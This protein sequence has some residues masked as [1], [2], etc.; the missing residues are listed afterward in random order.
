MLQLEQSGA[1]SRDASPRPERHS[2]PFFGSRANLLAAALLRV[3][4]AEYTLRPSLRRRLRTAD[5][6]LNFSVGFC[7]EDGAVAQ[8]ISFR[9]GRVR[10]RSGVAADVD[11]TLTFQ[12][13]DA[14]LEMLRLPPNEALTLIMKN[15]VRVNGNMTWMSAFNHL[16]SLLTRRRTARALA[17]SRA[18]F[19]AEAESIAAG[20]EMRRPGDARGREERLAGD[21]SDAVRFLDDPYLGAYTLMDFPRLK[22]FLDIHFETRPEL[23]P[24]RPVILTEWFRE[25][26]FDTRADGTPWNPV[27]RQGEAF[28]HL[29]AARKPIVR[30]GDLLAGTTTGKEI[31]VVIYPDAHGTLIWGE[32]LTVGDRPINSYDVSP[33]D[34]AA[35]HD[36]YPFWT[37]RSFR[38]WVRDTY[39]EP[40]GQRID[41][42]LAV[43]FSVKTV[44]L[45]HT[46]PDFPRLLRKGARGMID[47]LDAELAGERHPDE[48][49][50]LRAMRLTLE[51][52]VAYGRNLAAECRRLAAAEQNPA[53]R[54]ELERMAAV[55]ERVP[56]HP[57]ETLDEAVQCVWTAWVGQHLENNNAGHS[58]G[59]L[60]QCLQPYFAADIA[61]LHGREDREAYVRHAIEL[62]GCLYMRCTDHL[63]LYPDL[64]NFLFGGASSD[65]AITLGGVTRDGESAVNDMTYVLLK[66]TELL[67]IRDPNVN[68]RY[69]LEE[70]SDA[71]LKRLCEVN[72]ITT[73][74]PSIHGDENVMRSIE[75][76]G[77]PLEDRRDWAPTGCVEPTIAGKHMGHTGCMMFSLVAALEM[78]LFDGRHP[79]MRW[80]LGPRTG[81]PAAAAHATFEDFFA[82]YA[83]QLAFLADQAT[84]YNHQL[85]EAHAVLRPTPFLSSMIEGTIESGRDVT[86]GGA[87]YNSSGVACIG[88]TDVVD[89]LLAVKHLVYDGTTSFAELIDALNADFA[90]YDELY[91]LTRGAAPKFGSG[92]REALAMANRVTRL[93]HD[94]FSSKRNFRGGR[95]TTGFWSMSN[96]VVFGTLAGALPSGRRS[97]KAFTPGLTPSAAASPNLLDNLRDVA[98]LAPENMDNNVA[99]NVKYVPS[100]GDT[101]ERSVDNMFSYAKTYFELGGMQMQLNVVSSKVLCDA[102]ANPDDY[103]DLLVRISGYNAYFVTLNHDMQVE[104]I[105]RTEFCA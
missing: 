61:K 13:D 17:R 71:Y 99:F 10:V 56:E 59:R 72:L 68:A 78:A 89:S 104:L 18:R 100:A 34:V 23:C 80:R 40:L 95:Y 3:V 30:G 5:G 92:D 27:L 12:D 63:P 75:H 79:L 91:A 48:Q 7:T 97:G 98:A 58:L 74:T 65:Q 16:V 66:V 76:L 33:E 24:E 51:G 86:R 47:E 94:V 87:L 42:R 39:D 9:D 20:Y 54:A 19:D 50:V 4:A 6:R 2:K 31:G 32:L 62:L 55:N 49:D 8:T 105:E 69:S 102:M 41:E 37:H 52:I 64:G 29:M 14:L 84:T 53:R 96:H 35:L 22:R 103:R 81:D 11:T 46:I 60:D 83:A 21:R 77:Y 70:N 1:Q 73:A 36:I 44:A 28:K 90:G 38:E 43:Y 93:V 67:M 57:A 88:L 45:S 26:G 15:R 25:H 82:A 85:G 101:H